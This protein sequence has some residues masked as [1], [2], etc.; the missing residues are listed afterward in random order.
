MERYCDVC[1]RFTEPSPVLRRS[2]VLDISV[3]V[4]CERRIKESMGEESEESF[5]VAARCLLLDALQNIR[6]ESCHWPQLVT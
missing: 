2:D 6:F 4:E 5:K 1:C 3:C